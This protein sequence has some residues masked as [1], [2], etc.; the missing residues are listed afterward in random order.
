MDE[1]RGKSLPRRI[2]GGAITLTMLS[3]GGRKPGAAVR[4]ALVEI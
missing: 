4:S 1:S 2:L 3:I